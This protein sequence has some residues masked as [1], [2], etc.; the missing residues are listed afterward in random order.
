MLVS[1]A[2]PQP[3]ESDFLV[4]LTNDSSFVTS[5]DNGDIAEIFDLIHSYDHT[6]HQDIAKLLGN[7]LVSEHL[8]DAQVIY[9]IILRSYKKASDCNFDSF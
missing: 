3:K 5:Y 9:N 4:L 6:H 2:I 1:A 7:I 8:N